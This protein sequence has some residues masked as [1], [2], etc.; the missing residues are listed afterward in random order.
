MDKSQYR[1]LSA[2]EIDKFDG[3]DRVVAQNH[4][5]NVGCIIVDSTY[6]DPIDNEYDLEEIYQAIESTKMYESKN[7]K[8]MNGKENVNEEINPRLKGQIANR[9]MHKIQ[10]N[11]KY[12]KS[13][14]KTLI[15]ICKEIHVSPE[16]R[17]E[18]LRM[19]NDIMNQYEDFRVSQFGF[20]MA[21]SDKEYRGQ[22][23][24][25][26]YEYDEDSMYE[27]KKNT[28]TLTESELKKVIVESVKRILKENNYNLS[29]EEKYPQYNHDADR[30]WKLEFESNPEAAAKKAQSV[31][32]KFEN[33]D[34]RLY[35]N[36]KEYYRDRAFATF[37]KKYLKMN[38]YL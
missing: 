18:L 13:G 36:E 17:R 16:D 19:A 14:K 15:D 37:G 32:S 21:G 28:I 30:W 11:Y 27:S 25:Q 6:G 8:N 26:T 1:L 24:I 9:L 34:Y 23:D 38:G 7:R 29:G 12:L 20:G 22:D 10:H 35:A 3:Y 5:A 4:I 31:I 33:S 2:N